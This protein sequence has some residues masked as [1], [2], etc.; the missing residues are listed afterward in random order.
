MILSQKMKKLNKRTERAIYEMNKQ[1]KNAPVSTSSTTSETLLEEQTWKQLEAEW[2]RIDVLWRIKEETEREE[3]EKLNME[4]FESGDEGGED[5][6]AKI[7]KQEALDQEDERQDE[8][9][10]SEDSN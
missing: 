10:Q 6:L 1:A 8:L 4:I 3:I 5:L 2:K 9:E 7:R